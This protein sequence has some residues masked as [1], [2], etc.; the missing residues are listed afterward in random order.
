MCPRWRR[1]ALRSRPFVRRRS[2]FMRLS[3]PPRYFPIFAN[4][5]DRHTVYSDAFTMVANSPVVYALSMATA[6][7]QKSLSTRLPIG[8]SNF[9]PQ[10][11]S[12]ALPQ[13]APYDEAPYL[14]LVWFRWCVD[15]L[16][17][18]RHSRHTLTN[19]RCCFGIL[20]CDFLS[21][22]TLLVNRSRAGHVRCHYYPHPYRPNIQD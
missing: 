16:T 6:R 20:T 15:I 21:F 4:L 5:L 13:S 8:S 9:V 3:F 7:S 18:C 19:F 2:S 17:I 14:R 1:V 22:L 10:I 12:M 11:A